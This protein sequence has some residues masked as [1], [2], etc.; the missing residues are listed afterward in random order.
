MLFVV[1]MTKLSAVVAGIF[2]MAVRKVKWGI[3]F[4]AL[5][6]EIDYYF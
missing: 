2:S 6:K 1:F 4:L 3:N 5:S